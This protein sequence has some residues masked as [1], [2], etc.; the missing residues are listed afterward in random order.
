MKQKIVN[1]LL[2]LMVGA[3]MF[4]ARPAYAQEEPPIDLSLDRN[5]NQISDAVE[6]EMALL[7]TLPAEQQSA[8]IEHFVAKLPY[9]PETVALQ[10]RAIELST[11]LQ[12]AKP[13]EGPAI[14]DELT[15]VSAQLG[16]DPVIKKVGSDILTLTGYGIQD[17]ST[18]P[19]LSQLPVRDLKRGD[20]LARYSL[21]GTIFPWA[22]YYEHTGNFDGN[23]KVY[24]S[25]L[26]DGVNLRPLTEWTRCC[27]AVGL[28]RNKR[29]STSRMESAMNAAKDKYGYDGRTP[30]NWWNFPNKWM[31]DALYCSQLTWKIN[32]STGYDL[33]SNHWQYRLYMALKWSPAVWLITDPAVAPDEVMLSPHVEIKWRGFQG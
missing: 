9:S 12:T 15:K 30:Y 21:Y 14:L 2:V 17:D 4:S 11:S 10:Q 8:E 6:T 24:E 3:T 31:D 33:D 32:K 28:A 20:I 13:E 16:E 25:N 18:N 1:L 5:G 22:M 23:G 29:V 19:S 26:L 27:Q 7:Q